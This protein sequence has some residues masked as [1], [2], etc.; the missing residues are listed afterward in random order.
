ME[1]HSFSNHGSIAKAM[2]DGEYFARKGVG[3]V[4]IEPIKDLTVDIFVTHTAAD[5]DPKHG[6]N[7][8]YYR[9]R[10]VKEMMEKYVSKSTA[11]VV[12]LGGDFNAEPE[13]IEGKYKVSKSE[14]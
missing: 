11:D 1:F 14:I 13:K 8:S 3:K 4:R 5:P 6:Y 12:I 10:Q 2:I 9:I 7:N